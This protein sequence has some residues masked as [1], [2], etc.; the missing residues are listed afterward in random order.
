LLDVLHI[1]S[2]RCWR[3][4]IFFGIEQ[5]DTRQERKQP[6]AEELSAQH[7]CLRTVVIAGVGARGYYRRLG[8]SLLSDEEGGYMVK[9]LPRAVRLA[10]Q[11]RFAFGERA[12]RV[13]PVLAALLLWL[14][15]G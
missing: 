1:P 9:P 13:L 2:H 6:G 11:L 14:L 7:G 8:Y 12:A 4:F 3:P 15:L 10:A 5:H